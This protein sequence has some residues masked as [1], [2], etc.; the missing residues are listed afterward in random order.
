MGGEYENQPPRSLEWLRDRFFKLESRCSPDGRQQWLNWVVRLSTS[1]LAGY[2]QATV[3]DDGHAGIAYE[4]ASAQWGRGIGRKAVG[5]MIAE[6]VG[7]Y[8]VHT[9]TA[10]LKRENGR[11]RCLLERLRFTLAPAELA[12]MREIDAGEI[13]MWRKWPAS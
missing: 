8:R 1:E 5:A 7:H 2:V 10:T 11:S 4:L 3:H 6:L 9:L 13:M 12:R